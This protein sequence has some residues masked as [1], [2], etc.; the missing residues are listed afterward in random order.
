MD[1]S[2]VRIAQG[3]THFSPGSYENMPT[4][5]TPIPNL[6]MSGDWI[7]N[8]HGSFSQGKKN[9]GSACWNSPVNEK[10]KKIAPFPDAFVYVSSRH[11][12]PRKAH[13]LEPFFI[14]Y[15]RIIVVEVESLLFCS[16]LLFRFSHSAYWL[17]TR[18]KRLYT[19]ANPARGLLNR[20]KR[21][22]R[23][24]LA[25]PPPPAPHAART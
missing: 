9:R 14:F 1:Y 7:V 22:K 12:F 15:T 4:L 21:T 3:V 17:P 16:F 18:R 13:K 10:K 11:G 5:E 6:F 2:V 8:D 24:S 19:V 23:K 25:A 20:E